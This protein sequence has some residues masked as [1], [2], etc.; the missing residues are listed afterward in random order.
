[1]HVQVQHSL[2][3]SSTSPSSCKYGLRI[4]YFS[5]TAFVTDELL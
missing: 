4:G 2:N 5:T 3:A 1:M